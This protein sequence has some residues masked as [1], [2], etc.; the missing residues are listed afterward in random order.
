VTRRIGLLVVLMIG[1]AIAGSQVVAAV[2]Y[3]GDNDTVSLIR[4][5]ATWSL[6]N[7]VVGVILVWQRPALRFPWIMFASGLVMALL[8]MS[9]LRTGGDPNGVY[10]FVA[11][12]PALLAQV[13]PTGRPISGPLGWATYVGVANIVAMA[14]KPGPLQ[15]YVWL[16]SLLATIPVVAVRFRRSSGAERAQLKWFLY[17]V[18]AAVACWLAASLAGRLYGGEWAVSLALA[19]PS[20]GIVVSLLRYHLYDI[21]R[22]ISRTASY[23][24][25]TG[26][27][28]ATYGLVVAV[29]LHVLPD[30]SNIAVAAATLTAAAVAR[31]AVTRVRSLVDRRFDRTR[32]DQLRIVGGFGDELAALVRPTDVTTR[33]LGTVQSSLQPASCNL[34]LQEPA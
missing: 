29:V 28:L 3:T 27:V 33:L 1:A 6:L 22:I 17:S 16:G 5:A 4:A 34:W 21:D 12:L 20:L 25:V 15:A 23:V 8:V 11:A 30:S 19:L 10:F 9:S 18:T 7:V 2:S 24:V 14:I 26:L 31:P 32:Y 13:F